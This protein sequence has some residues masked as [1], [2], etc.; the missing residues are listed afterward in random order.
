MYG[1]PPGIDLSFLNG[2]QLEGLMVG[3]NDLILHFDNETEIRIST[4]VTAV[5]PG[6]A[7]VDY[8]EA[9]PAGKWAIDLIGDTVEG[10]QGEAIG[11]LTLRFASGRLMSIY[12]EDPH[13][14][15]YTI[16]SP[17]GLIVV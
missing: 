13:Y 10:V 4:T 8:A 11:T 9:R 7:P 17:N 6:A 1:L 12:D 15:C 14:E 3:F 5:D 2:L 16:T